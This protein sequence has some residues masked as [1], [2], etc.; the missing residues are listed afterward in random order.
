MP[1]LSIDFNVPHGLVFV[2]LI[3]LVLFRLFEFEVEEVA[4]VPLVNLLI[5]GELVEFQF[6]FELIELA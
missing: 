4:A 6:Q 2:L 3:S 5:K 1:V